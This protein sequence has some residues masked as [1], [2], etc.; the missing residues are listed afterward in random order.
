MPLTSDNLSPPISG[1]RKKRK[2]IYAHDT[3]VL[4]HL[5]D[6]SSRELLSLS[7]ASDHG[8]SLEGPPHWAVEYRY[9]TL[10]SVMVYDGG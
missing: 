3:R 2:I 4:W 9:V 10:R 6:G 5:P 1:K 8:P 7:P